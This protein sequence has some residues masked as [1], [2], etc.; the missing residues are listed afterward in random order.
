VGGKILVFIEFGEGRIGGGFDGGRGVH[1]FI[2]GGG[3]EVGTVFH[4]AFV[5]DMM[6]SILG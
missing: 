4:S 2:V 1:V 3:F 6:I 5:H